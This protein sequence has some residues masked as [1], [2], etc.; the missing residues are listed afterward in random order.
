MTVRKTRSSMPEDEDEAEVVAE[1]A[2]L[3]SETT[4]VGRGSVATSAARSKSTLATRQ[5]NRW[6]IDQ[7]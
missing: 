3:F 5:S 1:D 2:D 4:S 7:A 6:A